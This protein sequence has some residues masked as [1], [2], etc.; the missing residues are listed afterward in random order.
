VTPEQKNLLMDSL[1]YLNTLGF[2]LR[3]P[4]GKT[5]EIEVHAIPRILVQCD[6][7]DFLTELIDTLPKKA[8]EEQITEILSLIACHGSYRAGD[9]LSFRQTKD[10]LQELLQ[11]ENPHI[12]AHGRP[13]YFKIPYQDLLRQVQ[14]I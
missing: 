7:K 13:L 8:F 10:L 1:S 3:V 9:L 14:R 2:D 12:C 11:T 5:R 6:L 4:K